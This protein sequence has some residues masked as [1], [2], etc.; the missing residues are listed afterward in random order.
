LPPALAGGCVNL[1]RSFGLCQKL[2]IPRRCKEA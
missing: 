1:K 2:F